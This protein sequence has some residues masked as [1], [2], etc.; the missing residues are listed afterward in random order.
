MRSPYVPFVAAAV[1]LWLDLAS[2]A[3]AQTPPSSLLTDP[4]SGSAGADHL[5]GPPAPSPVTTGDREIEGIR[6]S[7][8]EVRAE[9]RP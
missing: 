3:M 4:P 8:F 6:R 5:N 7:A 2:A 1:M 9:R